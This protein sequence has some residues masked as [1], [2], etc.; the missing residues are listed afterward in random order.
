M[1]LKVNGV[2][3]A[4]YPK[5]FAVTA[6]DLDDGEATV[7]TADGTLNRDRVTVK[8]QIDMTFAA[9][10]WSAM[11]ALLQSMADTFFDLYYP[12]PMEGTYVTKTFYVGNRPCPAAIFRD[13]DI[14]WS[15]L[16]ITLT[17]R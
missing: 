17:E 8:R 14:Y 6:L 13:N 16:K 3:I 10:K 7:R 5:E 2:D 1:D 15:G 11:A 12:D 4:A 9:L